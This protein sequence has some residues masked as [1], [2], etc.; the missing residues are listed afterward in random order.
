[1]HC[2][3]SVAGLGYRGPAV[4][5]SCMCLPSA[6]VVV[7]VTACRIDVHTHTQGAVE[8]AQ[9]ITWP[10][11]GKV[12]EQAALHLGRGHAAATVADVLFGIPPINWQGC[13]SL[14]APMP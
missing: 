12:R 6:F 5:Q 2:L 7:A 11:P 3:I 1:M 8:E 9:L 4:S 10:T 14:C 13:S